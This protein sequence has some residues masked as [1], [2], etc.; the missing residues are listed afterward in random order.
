MVVEHSADERLTAEDLLAALG[1]EPV[2]YREPADALE[3]L[4]RRGRFDAVVVGRLGGRDISLAFLRAL[5]AAEP[6]LPLILAVRNLDCFDTASLA[7]LN[8]SQIISHPLRPAELA[9]TVASCF[10]RRREGPPRWTLSH[11]A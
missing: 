3:A 8:I 6:Q 11:P 5:R 4:E 9:A 1:Y 7:A 2:G 10:A